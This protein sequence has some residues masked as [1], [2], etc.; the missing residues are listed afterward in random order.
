MLCEWLRTATTAIAESSSFSFRHSATATSPITRI[1]TSRHVASRHVA[2][3]SSRLDS[4][5]R[6]ESR[7]VALRCAVPDIF[8]SR[9]SFLDTRQS[10]VDSAAQRVASDKLTSKLR[11]ENVALR[12]VA[13]RRVGR[14][15]DAYYSYLLVSTYLYGNYPPRNSDVNSTSGDVHS[16]ADEA[17]RGDAS[18]VEN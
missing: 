8:S 4:S 15:P 7:R 11:G 13:S 10:T 17:R 14:P 12:C 18:L 1:G 16:R 5:G 9:R 3:S 2:S 6:I